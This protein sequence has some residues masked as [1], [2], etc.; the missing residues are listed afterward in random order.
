MWLQEILVRRRGGHLVEV[1]LPEFQLGDQRFLVP[2]QSR[3]VPLCL[4]DEPI[5]VDDGVLECKTKSHIHS[6]MNISTL[7]LLVVNIG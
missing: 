2:L 5:I 4:R 6:L 3:V 7:H 1:A